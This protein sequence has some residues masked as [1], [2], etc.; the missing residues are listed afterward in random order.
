MYIMDLETYLKG[1]CDQ[2]QIKPGAR[3]VDKDGKYFSVIGDGLQCTLVDENSMIV[4]CWIYQTKFT[5]KFLKENYNITAFPEAR[6][7]FLRSGDCIL[8]ETTPYMIVR[9]DGNNTWC[10]L[11]LTTMAMHIP[12][13]VL[14][15]DYL[16][17]ENFIS[18]IKPYYSISGWKFASRGKWN[19]SEAIKTIP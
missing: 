4:S 6:K 10:L 2:R 18:M 3:L 12:E 5:V 14:Q 1:E 11:N 19:F 9:N 16:T 17:Y 7:N 13:L 15:S 8:H